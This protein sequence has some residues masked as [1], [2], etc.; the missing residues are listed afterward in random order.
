MAVFTKIDPIDR[1]IQVMLAD[2]LSPQARSKALAE[3]ADTQIDGAAEAARQ[4][5]GTTPRY[6]VTVDGRQGAPLESV[7]PDGVIVAEFELLTDVLS[8]IGEQLVLHSPVSSGRYQDSHVLMADGVAIEPGLKIPPAEE[9]VFVNVQPYARKIERG[10]SSQAPDG[11]YQAVATLAA[12]RFNN[13]AKISFNYRTP[14][15]G[16]IDKWAA[17]PSAQAHAARHRRRSNV[18]EWLRN[19]PAVVVKTG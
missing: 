16:A 2:D 5:I 7:K 4:A 18:G 3:F 10:M 9:Y 12:R 13:V 15:F 11:V 19:Q 8:W 6:T 14:L 1:D 17:T